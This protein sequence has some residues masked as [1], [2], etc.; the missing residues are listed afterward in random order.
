[1]LKITISDSTFQQILATLGGDEP[2][3]RWWVDEY[4]RRAEEQLAEALREQAI[5]SVENYGAKHRPIDGLGQCVRRMGKKL[6]DWLHTYAPGYVYD[7]AFL[8]QLVKDNGHMCLK[9]TYQPKAQIIVPRKIGPPVI[10]AKPAMTTTV[11]PKLQ[12][13]ALCHE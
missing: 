11:T 5:V 7:N 9:P 3:A 4:K 2:T 13:T 10:T 12:P 1:M 8:K 6:N